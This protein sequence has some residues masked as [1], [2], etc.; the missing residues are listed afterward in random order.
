MEIFRAAGDSEFWGVSVR[1]KIGSVGGG[2][3]RVSSRFAVICSGV[4]A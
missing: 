2:M 4:H 3:V 1:V